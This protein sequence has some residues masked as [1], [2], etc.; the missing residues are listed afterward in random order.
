MIAGSCRCGVWIR[1][2]ALEGEIVAPKSSWSSRSGA[3]DLDSIKIEVSIESSIGGYLDDYQEWLLIRTLAE[4]E[5]CGWISCVR[6][7]AVVIG[8]SVFDL[9]IKNLS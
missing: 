1:K 9:R 6:S 3:E 8:V 5:A 4:G 7:K 2:S